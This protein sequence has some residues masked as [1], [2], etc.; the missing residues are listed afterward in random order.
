ME[1]DILPLA[2]ILLVE[3]LDTLSFHQIIHRSENLERPPQTVLP[4]GDSFQRDDDNR[5][6]VDISR[7]RPPCITWS[8]SSRHD[9][10]LA[11]LSLGAIRPRL[12]G[13]SVLDVAF[14]VD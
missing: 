14:Y 9:D 7:T 8:H 11:L 6:S 2:C 4:C 5:T 1:F 10:L 12:L 3:S 13:A